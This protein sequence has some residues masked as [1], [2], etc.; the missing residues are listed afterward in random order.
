MNQL[1]ID[2][3]QLTGLTEAFLAHMALVFLRVGGAVALLPALGEHLLPQRVKLAATLALT[4]IV[5]PAVPS[6]G[7]V[8]GPAAMLAEALAGLILGFSLRMLILGLQT[9][10]T[11]A[12]QSVSLAQ[13]FNGAGPEPQPIVASLLVLGGT[14]L[15]VAM[16]GLSHAARLL[17]LSYDVMPAGNFPDPAGMAAW[18]TRR[19]AA[20]F[21]QAFA[22]AAPFVVAALLYNL[23]LGVINR[24]MPALMVVFIGAPALTLGGLM[25]LAVVAPIL[26]AAWQQIVTVVLAAPFGG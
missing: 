12:A 21:R 3:S 15:F 24:A 14:A 1:V 11:L 10:G 18:A 7:G 9:A 26:L 4:A 5:A 22:L 23:A 25:L 6:T 20:V 8:F 2:L 16:G 13:M 19:G 17:I